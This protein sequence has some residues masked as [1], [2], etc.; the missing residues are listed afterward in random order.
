LWL[1][2][3]FFAAASGVFIETSEQARVASAAGFLFFELKDCHQTQFAVFAIHSVS[4]VALR[5]P[6]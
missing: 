4:G 5:I 2:N 6:R 3:R 1:I